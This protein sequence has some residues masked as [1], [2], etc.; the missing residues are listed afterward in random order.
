MLGRGRTGTMLACYLC[1]EENLDAGDAI[2]KTRQL[3][4]ASIE[5]RQQEQA[6]MRFCQRL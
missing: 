2:L 6:V 5:T 1:K 4:P 3:R